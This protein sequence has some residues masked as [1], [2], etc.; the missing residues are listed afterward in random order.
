MGPE[1]LQ[2]E[3]ME[4]PAWTL[5]RCLNIFRLFLFKGTDKLLHSTDR[6]VPHHP[7]QVTHILIHICSLPP[8]FFLLK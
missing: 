1:Y 3:Q 4:R 8:S 7:V 6:V 5:I 2:E